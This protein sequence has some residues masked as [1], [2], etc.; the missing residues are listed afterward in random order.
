MNLAMIGGVLMN[1]VVGA[2]VA[3]AMIW[4]HHPVHMG[5]ALSSPKP[6]TRNRSRQIDSNRWF[7]VMIFV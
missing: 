3:R 7:M 6:G 4:L 1:L 2:A 5:M